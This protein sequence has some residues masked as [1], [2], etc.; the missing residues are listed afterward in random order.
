MAKPL[1]FRH[2]TYGIPLGHRPEWEAQVALGTLLSALGRYWLYMVSGSWGT[3]NDE[4]RAEQLL[5]LPLRLD[6]DHPSTE[7]IVTAVEQLPYAALLKTQLSNTPALH[8]VAPILAVLD[9]A[10]SDLFEM[11]AAEHDLV[12]DFWAARQPTGTAAVALS[13]N[14][15]QDQV[16]LS[17]YLDVFRTAW[18][19]Q[20][21]EDTELDRQLW[22]DPRA[23][24][25][26]AVFETRHAGE[27]AAEV[28]Q[29][30]DAW[31]A[32]LKRYNLVLHETQAG[33]LL[34]YGMVR[35]V[36]D[37]A[38]VI[39]KRNERRLWSPTAARE[40]AE[41]TIAQVMNLQRA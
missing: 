11:T 8:D 30:E 9:E 6:R 24:I 1:A 27:P 40:D 34:T 15:T 23:E 16:E 4:I 12:N 36:T 32:V 25:I 3:W 10:I 35:A 2:T 14:G 37:S 7:R 20:L 39:V 5:D 33:G 21:A 38:I 18:R 29:D 17:R 13:P 22:Q 19:P 28:H 41:A 31:S 26:A